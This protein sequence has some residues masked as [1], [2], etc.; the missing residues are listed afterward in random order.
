M[1]EGAP[2]REIVQ[3]AQ[4]EDIDLIV[5]STHGHRGFARMFLGSTAERVVRHATCPV[6][7][8]REK[9]HE[10]I[11]PSSLAQPAGRALPA[12]TKPALR[13]RQKAS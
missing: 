7:I 10:F 3:A 1:R 13:K 11:E 5:I 9:E 12:V 2:Y 8:V 4:D 6:L